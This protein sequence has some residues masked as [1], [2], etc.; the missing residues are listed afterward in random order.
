MTDADRVDADLALL[1]SQVQEALL[2]R[3]A[4]AAEDFGFVEGAR[5]GEF[6]GDREV[7][8]AERADDTQQF[9]SDRLT[10]IAG[11]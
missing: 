10:L 9:L 1:E 5:V 3:G 8:H 4:D 7:E 11:C 2:P 6:Q